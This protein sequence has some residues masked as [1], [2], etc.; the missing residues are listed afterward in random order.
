MQQGYFVFPPEAAVR[1]NVTLLAGD[2]PLRPQ[3]EH[4]RALDCNAVFLGFLPRD[5]LPAFYSLLDIFVF[6]VRIETQRL[7]ALE[8]NAREM[9]VVAADVG[10]L[11]TTVS[12]AK[13]DTTTRLVM[14]RNFSRRSNAV[15]AGPTA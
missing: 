7:V 8:T 3:V 5:E 11:S 13:P 9:P 14:S 6:P 4:A 15:G 1:L 2:G 12:T 10:V